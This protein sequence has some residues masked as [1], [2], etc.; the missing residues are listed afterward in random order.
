M[1]V[2]A[3]STRT[4]IIEASTTFTTTATTMSTHNKFICFTTFLSALGCDAPV[5]V[6]NQHFAQSFVF[7][8]GGNGYSWILF[9]C[10]LESFSCS[11]LCWYIV[12]LST[13]FDRKAITHTQTL[14]CQ[15]MG[16]DDSVWSPST[17]QNKWKPPC[18][19][20]QSSIFV[21]TSWC[22]LQ[23]S[24]STLS[25]SSSSSSSF[26]C[27]ILLESTQ[28]DCNLVCVRLFVCTGFWYA[29]FGKLTDA[30]DE[31]GWRACMPSASLCGKS[32]IQFHI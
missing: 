23:C 32:R 28:N 14:A 27:F 22:G 4:Q 3:W 11:L 10:W 26:T 2:L 21:P 9:G 12:L 18:Q 20:S 15:L 30:L 5:T 8:L 24:E 25:S 19:T 16:D 6:F 29:N 1:L 13:C 17:N 31:D 7:F